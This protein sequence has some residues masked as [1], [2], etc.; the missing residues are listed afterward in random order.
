MSPGLARGSASPCATRCPPA[1]Q[2][3]PSQENPG[4]PSLLLPPTTPFRPL[5]SSEGGRETES[6]STHALVAERPAGT[7]HPS[8]HGSR[9][10]KFA[11]GPGCPK[12]RVVIERPLVSCGVRRGPPG[13]GSSLAPVPLSLAPPHLLPVSVELPTRAFHADGLTRHVD[14]CPASS[15][16]RG[17][18]GVALRGRGGTLSY[19]TDAGSC[20]VPAAGLSPQAWPFQ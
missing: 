2:L 3:A 10:A 16:Y 6:P 4:P 8:F 20:P 17:G 18:G 11:G 12:P 1:R 19:V 9:D 7:Q 14:R 5:H 15:P 13:R